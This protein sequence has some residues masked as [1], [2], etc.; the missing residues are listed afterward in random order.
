VLLA[1]PEDGSVGTVTVTALSCENCD[2]RAVPIDSSTRKAM[3]TAVGA[4]VTLTMA[5]QG[6]RVVTGQPPS[7]PVTVGPDEIQRLFGDAVA[8]R[9]LP[10]RQFV[11]YSQGAVDTFTPEALALVAEI[12]RLVGG[13]PAA[14]VT[15]IG[16]T[17]TTG[18][19]TANVALGLRRA[20]VV[21]D[22][23][24]QSGVN[25]E[26]IDVASHGEADLLVRT[27]DETAEAQNRR[28]EVIVR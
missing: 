20:A 26:R 7:P 6:T 8:A 2:W 18:D 17:D 27:P 5:N 14:D 13:R 12:A 15:V 21:R 3:V 11:L 4:S 25:P 10:P 24:L 19:A 1:D 22:L 16:H 28:V 23:L 9:P